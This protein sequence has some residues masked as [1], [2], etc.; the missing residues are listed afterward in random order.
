MKDI[1]QIKSAQGANEAPDPPRSG[2]GLSAASCY[3]LYSGWVRSLDGD[4]HKIGFKDLIRLYK[5]DPR[6]CFDGYDES[7]WAGRSRQNVI[8]L[9]PRQDGDYS[10]HNKEITRGSNDSPELER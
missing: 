10:L 8:E 6:K 3:A 5:L 2:S 4:W 9:H 7:K 1:D